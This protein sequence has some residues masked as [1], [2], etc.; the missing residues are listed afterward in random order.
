[1]TIAGSLTL[2][3]DLI[4]C[5]CASDRN[6]SRLMTLI[7]SCI[8]MEEHT[9]NI[10][11]CRKISAAFDNLFSSLIL[12]LQ[13]QSGL[14]CNLF[15]GKQWTWRIVLH[16]LHEVHCIS[17]AMPQR[18]YKYVIEHW[19]IQQVSF[20]SPLLNNRDFSFQFLPV[21]SSIMKVLCRNHSSSLGSPARIGFCSPC[22]SSALACTEIWVAH[23]VIPAMPVL[24]FPLLQVLPA[25]FGCPQFSGRYSRGFL[26]VALTVALK[27][28]APA[29]L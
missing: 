13:Q 5:S 15:K 27:G 23:I 16:E 18:T 10:S 14:L 11:T 26:V 7:L 19:K 22:C 2:Q 17:K 25:H 9:K 24:S 8:T 29:L 6:T 20:F 1:M 4:V 28:P 21:I 3:T 12:P